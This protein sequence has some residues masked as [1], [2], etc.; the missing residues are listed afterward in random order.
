MYA[1]ARMHRIKLNVW[2]NFYIIT[3]RDLNYEFTYFIYNVILSSAN[4]FVNAI[5]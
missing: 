2:K 4:L 3:G 1:L 5:Y